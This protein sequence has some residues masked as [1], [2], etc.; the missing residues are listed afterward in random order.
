MRCPDSYVDLQSS[1][2]LIKETPI[3]IGFHVDAATM[4]RYS[5]VPQL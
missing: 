3:G 5:A 2:Y 4:T 1:S